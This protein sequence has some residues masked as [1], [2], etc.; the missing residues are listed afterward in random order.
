MIN[1]KTRGAHD[2]RAMKTKRSR[3]RGERC[4][5][6]HAAGRKSRVPRFVSSTR[7]RE[8]EQ[9]GARK[10]G[11]VYEYARSRGSLA[12]R[13]GARNARIM[14][15]FELGSK[16]AEDQEGCVDRWIDRAN[17][18]R[19]RR[20]ARLRSLLPSLPLSLSL[21]LRFRSDRRF[22]GEKCRSKG[23]PVDDY[24]TVLK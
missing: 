2:A 12:D 19:L 11:R 15:A 6:A 20:R 21:F 3:V 9:D 10:R 14:R 17:Y 13:V 4:R 5:C 24:V 1:H 16:R 8:I 18:A 23:R 22:L 7:Y